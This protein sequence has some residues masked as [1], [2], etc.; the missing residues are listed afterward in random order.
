MIQNLCGEALNACRDLHPILYN[1]QNRSQKKFSLELKEKE[2]PLDKFTFE[3]HS[4]Q[5]VHTEG[6]YKNKSLRIG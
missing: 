6:K 3:K 4:Q 1:L 2:S 5:T